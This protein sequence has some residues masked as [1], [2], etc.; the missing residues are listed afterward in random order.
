MVIILLNAWFVKPSGLSSPVSWFV[1]P[2]GLWTPW[3]LI[4]FELVALVPDAVLALEP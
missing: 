2:S 1:K 3:N 4:I